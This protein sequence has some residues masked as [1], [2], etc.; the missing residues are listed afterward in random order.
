MP[1]ERLRA[2][3]VIPRSFSDSVGFLWKLVAI[4]MYGTAFT[5]N[6]VYR[7]ISKNMY[8]YVSNFLSLSLYLYIYIYVFIYYTHVY[9]CAG[10]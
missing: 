5:N 7:C 4:H 6:C 1:W 3:A 8:A 9:I 2:Q 10:R